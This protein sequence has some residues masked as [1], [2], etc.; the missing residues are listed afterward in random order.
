MPIEVSGVDYES[1]N[2]LR[3]CERCDLR[4]MASMT[5]VGCRERMA[6]AA[7]EGEQAINRLNRLTTVE[8]DKDGWCTLAR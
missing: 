5:V 7:I 2:G 6:I 8:I 1:G 4:K 3:V